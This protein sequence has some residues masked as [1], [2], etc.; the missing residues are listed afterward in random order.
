[1]ATL[2]NIV[3]VLVF[4]QQVIAV[5]RDCSDFDSLKSCNECIRCGGNWCKNKNEVRNFSSIKRSGQKKRG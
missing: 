2:W 3:V 5:Q 1:M 4:I